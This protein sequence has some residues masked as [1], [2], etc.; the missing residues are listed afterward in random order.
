MTEAEYIT[1]VEGPTPDFRP[2]AYSFHT[3]FPSVLEGRTVSETYVCEL[4]TRNGRDILDRCQNAWHEGRPVRLD[5]PDD[6]GA[7]QEADVA[8]IR[9]QEIEAGM[10]L[11]LWVDLPLEDDEEEELDEDPNDFRF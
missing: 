9:L 4:R 10:V 6:I 11:L 5:F 3:F 1:I 8:A 7:R 2:M